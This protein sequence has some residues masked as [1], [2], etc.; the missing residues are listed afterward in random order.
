MHERPRNNLEQQATSAMLHDT[1]GAYTFAER[2][3]EGQTRKINLS[4]G[5][6]EKYFDAHSKEAGRFL[7]ICGADAMAINAA[8]LHDTVEKG[9]ATFDDIE[10]EFG[11]ETRTIVQLVSKN[12][13]LPTDTPEQKF[14]QKQDM[15][16]R[17]TQPDTPVRALEVKVADNFVTVIDSIQEILHFK[18]T[19]HQQGFNFDPWQRI[20]FMRGVLRAAG[21]RAGDSQVLQAMVPLFEQAIDEFE[22]LVTEYYPDS[23]GKEFAA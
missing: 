21:N 23:K 14:V 4:G 11:R 12:N 16:D 9:V 17:L 18:D 20:A 8:Y 15:I 10:R 3:H 1:R 19:Y 22:S 2:A 5:D 6:P 7:A 13:D